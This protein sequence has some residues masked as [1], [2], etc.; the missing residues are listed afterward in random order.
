MDDP[1]GAR[2]DPARAATPA[3]RGSEGPRVDLIAVS[4]RDDFLEQVG[5][6]LD[7]ESTLRHVD[8]IEA[9]GA[10][11]V[12]GR[13]QLMLL[14]ARDQQDVGQAVERLLSLSDAS[15]VVVFAPG[16]QTDSVAGAIRGSAAFAVLEI[17]IETAKT[18]AVLDGAREEALSR[19]ALLNPVIPPAAIAARPR[20]APEPVLTVVE[21]VPIPA[22]EPARPRPPQVAVIGA[23][24]LVLAV[25]VAGWYFA[26]RPEPATDQPAPTAAGAPPTGEPRD[27]AASGPAAIA[28]GSVEELL[29]GARAAFRERRYTAPDRDNALALYGAVLAQDPANGEALE[30]I[31]RIGAV[32]DQ[33]LKAALVE[34]RFDDAATLVAQLKII[35]PGDR[36]LARFESQIVDSRIAAA[37]ETGAMDRASELLRE[38]TS[39]RTL[40]TERQA[41]WH[42]A[43][44]RRQG[45]ARARQLVELI[46]TRI[47]EGRLL[48]PAKDSAKYHLEQLRRLSPDPRRRAAATRQLGQAYVQR[49]QAAQALRQPAEAERWLSEARALGFTATSF[50]AASSDASRSGAATRP[51]AERDRLSGLVQA[52]TRDGQLLDPAE[53]SAV[54]YLGELRSADPTGVQTAIVASELSARLIERARTSLDQRALDAAQAHLAAARPLG[55]NLTEVDELESRLA[56]A[57]RAASVAPQF[58]QTAELKRTRFVP[59]A[60]PKQALEDGVQGSVRVRITVDTDG[61]VKSAE[62]IEST[63]AGVFDEATLAAVKRWRFKPAEVNGRAVEASTL[64][65]L[66]FKPDNG[67]QR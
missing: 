36:E 26:S 7:G 39:A 21:A 20:V 57:R 29:E 62:I 18:A 2:P 56:T 43:I 15:V 45:D 1:I 11:V 55:L 25:L 54:F 22:G 10:Q 31:E 41:H 59:P 35:R 53:D 33:R 13:A 12:A 42:D 27:V 60:Y 6:A 30:G 46:A 44:S 38:A 37:V 34:R 67:T 63:P 61:R 9:A 48:E 32:L 66:V 51:A 28:Q 8:A 16:A 23:V 65:S 19:F 64:Q 40:T 5:P 24:F 47:E 49:A 3:G 52:R 50:A 17:P 58:V 4:A 14:D